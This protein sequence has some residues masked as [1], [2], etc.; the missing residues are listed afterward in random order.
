MTSPSRPPVDP[1]VP[2]CDIFDDEARMRRVLIR[3]KFAGFGRSITDD[4]AQVINHLASLEL[5][6]RETSNVR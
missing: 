3:L 2:E 1:T 5:H 4:E 6:R